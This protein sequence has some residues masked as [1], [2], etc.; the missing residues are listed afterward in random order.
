MQTSPNK[1]LIETFYQKV[2]NESRIEMISEVFHTDVQEYWK[3][4]STR[5]LD[6]LKV[7]VKLILLIEE[8]DYVVCHLERTDTWKRDKQSQR[9]ENLIYP[10]NFSIT[11]KAVWLFKIRDNKIFKVRKLV[12]ELS[13][14]ILKSKILDTIPRE[15]EEEIE[16]YLNQLRNQGILEY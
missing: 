4:R 14:A 7:D 3:E 9:F 11:Y 15:S 12:S 8:G 1:K 6:L 2:V 5:T 10:K 16:D 13:S